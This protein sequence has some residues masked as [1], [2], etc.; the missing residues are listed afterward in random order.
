[1]PKKGDQIAG[2]DTQVAAFLFG[3]ARGATVGRRRRPELSERSIIGE[4]MPG[5]RES[6]A[7]CRAGAEP[8]RR[9]GAWRGRR[10]PGSSIVRWHPDGG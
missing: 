8:I 7:G 10:R 6:L 2:S 1:M 4:E 9:R 3:L 5:V